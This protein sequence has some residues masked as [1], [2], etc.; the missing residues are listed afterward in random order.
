MGS[1]KVFVVTADGTVA[2]LRLAN[3]EVV[4]THS[5]G[6]P[7][8]GK[9]GRVDYA[10]RLVVV[11]GDGMPLQALDSGSGR[12]AWTTSGTNP[13]EPVDGISLIGDLVVAADESGIAAFA[14]SDGELRWR[15][16]Y[17]P[18]RAASGEAGFVVAFVGS[19]SVVALDVDDGSL[20]WRRQ[21][22]AMPSG[23]A[24]FMS[25]D[26]LIADADGFLSRL[27]GETG[28]TV[29]R[30]DVVGCV[31]CGQASV[32]A[33]QPTVV[34]SAVV[35]GTAVGVVGVGVNTGEV[36]WRYPTATPVQSSPLPS[37]AKSIAV[38]IAD[39][40]SIVELDVADGSP[41][42]AWPTQAVP[43]PQVVITPRL[44]I[45]ALADGRIHALRR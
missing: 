2:G 1:G 9:V 7:P 3:G 37:S 27:H 24:A 42:K 11:G 39:P 32:V 45:V 44:A 12:L 40:P 41:V 5:S 15:S 10:G 43:G 22:L 30:T 38:A 21:L 31:R 34:G 28:E 36:L 20:K 17:A 4:W 33:S 26:V 29:W 16:P 18:A 25:G 6:S 13:V 19:D 8:P 23:R 35:V 14:R